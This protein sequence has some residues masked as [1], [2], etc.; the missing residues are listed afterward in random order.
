MVKRNVSIEKQTICGIGE[1]H[2]LL[3]RCVGQRAGGTL[4]PPFLIRFDNR[5]NGEWAEGKERDHQYS[6]FK[7]NPFFFLFSRRRLE[8]TAKEQEKKIKGELEKEKEYGLVEGFRDTKQHHSSNNDDITIAQHHPMSGIHANSATAMQL[9]HMNPQPRSPS[10]TTPTSATPLHLLHPIPSTQSPSLQ[11]F[12]PVRA[13]AAGFSSSTIPQTQFTWISSG[14]GGESTSTQLYSNNRN[15]GGVEGQGLSLSLSSL[16]HLEAVKAEEFR[17]GD[18]GMVYHNQGSSS[19]YQTKDLG[20]HHQHQPLPLQGMVVN[21]D[22]QVH[23]GYSSSFGVINLLRNSK[24]AKAAQDLLEEFCSV[25]RGQM[26]NIRLGKQKKNSNTKQ[27]DGEP[28]SSLSKDLPPLSAAERIEYQRKKAALLSMLD[29]ARYFSLNKSNIY[30]FLSF[31]LYPF[32]VQSLSLYIL[33]KTLT[34][35]LH[36]SFLYHYYVSFCLIEPPDSGKF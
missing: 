5:V 19:S 23:V 30:L 22:H 3:D 7:S 6:Q 34:F 36:I 33:S 8:I 28:S 20:N 2:L 29:E 1:L 24:Y 11:E 31:F 16:Q 25:G 9:F 15:G 27:S 13:P 14:G 26:K 12:H 17:M 21:Q 35:T 10:P 18:S 32:K 4:C